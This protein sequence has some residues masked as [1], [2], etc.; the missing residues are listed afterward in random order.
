MMTEE[1]FYLVD[2]RRND[3]AKT[4]ISLDFKNLKELMKPSNDLEKETGGLL[5]LGGF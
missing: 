1:S 4:H 3:L 5:D 2:A